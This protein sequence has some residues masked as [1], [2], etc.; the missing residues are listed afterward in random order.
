MARRAARWKDKA[1]EC[2]WEEQHERCAWCG[3]RAE[4]LARSGTHAEGGRQGRKW[5]EL[6]HVTAL[7][8][9][10]TDEAENVVLA[11]GL[12]NRRREH[13]TLEEWVDR[14]GIPTADRARRIVV[15]ALLTLTD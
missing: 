3:K 7:H 1:R 4:G 2:L 13:F 5:L 11:C 6:D 12:C 15:A 9:G 14:V 10:G 8:D